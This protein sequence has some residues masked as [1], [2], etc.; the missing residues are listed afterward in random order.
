M[1]LYILFCTTVQNLC[2]IKI[3]NYTNGGHKLMGQNNHSRQ[4]VEE[5]CS[6]PDLP[7]ELPGQQW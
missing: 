2:I 4:M 5:N 1:I 3:S 7:K 6:I